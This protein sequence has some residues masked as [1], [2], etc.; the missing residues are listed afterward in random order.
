M[1]RVDTRMVNDP[2]TFDSTRSFFN[3]P[4]PFVLPVL[5]DVAA[6]TPCEEIR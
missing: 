2:L 4:M 3:E 5:N 6:V 1:S